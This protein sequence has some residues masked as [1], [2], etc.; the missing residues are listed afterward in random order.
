MAPANRYQARIGDGSVW[1]L[2]GYTSGADEASKGTGEPF[3]R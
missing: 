2:P 1:V 3:L